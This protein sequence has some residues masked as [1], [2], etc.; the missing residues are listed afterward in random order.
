[1]PRDLHDAPVRDRAVVMDP[2]TDLGPQLA[3]HGDVGPHGLH[4]RRDPRHGRCDPHV[5]PGRT[6]G[7]GWR[8]LAGFAI[9]FAC[10]SPWLFA[11]CSAV[12]RRPGRR[13]RSTATAARS[14]IT[15]SASRT[16]R[17]RRAFAARC[18]AT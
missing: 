10:D 15:I 5:R 16:T 11:W 17:C 4:R 8:G 7:P 13:R 14:R 12:A 6:G 1:G 18:R 9:T 2:R 3:V